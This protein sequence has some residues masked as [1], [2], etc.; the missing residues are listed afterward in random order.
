LQY[1]PLRLSDYGIYIVLTLKVESVN[2]KV[3]VSDW[4]DVLVRLRLILG[5]IA[6]LLSVFGLINHWYLT[7]M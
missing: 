5:A 3:G 7:G 6:F 1:E 2:V 4:W